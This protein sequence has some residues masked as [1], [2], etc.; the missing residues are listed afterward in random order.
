MFPPLAKTCFVTAFAQWCFGVNEF[1][2]LICFKAQVIPW[3]TWRTWFIYELRRGGGCS[4]CH[5]L[6]VTPCCSLT[7]ARNTMRWRNK[8]FFKSTGLIQAQYCTVLN[9]SP[10]RYQF[11]TGIPN[12]PKSMTSW[13]WSRLSFSFGLQKLHK[14][15]ISTPVLGSHHADLRAVLNEDLHHRTQQADVSRVPSF[16]SSAHFN[17]S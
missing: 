13:L 8:F 7:S 14:M 10:P 1:T 11:S 5:S 15:S 16:I 6:S 2:V 17:W 3:S 4:S 9:A 12:K